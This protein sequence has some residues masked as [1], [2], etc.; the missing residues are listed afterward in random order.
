MPEG[1]WIS[2]G[3][4]VAVAPAAGIPKKMCQPART[5]LQAVTT[6]FWNCAHTLPFLCN[7]HCTHGVCVALLTS[8][9]GASYGALVGLIVPVVVPVVVA[10]VVLSLAVTLCSVIK[11]QFSV[12]GSS[13]KPQKHGTQMGGRQGGEM[14]HGQP[15]ISACLL[16]CL[17]SCCST[18]APAAAAFVGPTPGVEEYVDT[19]S[20]PSPDI[21]PKGC[22]CTAIKHEP[23]YGVVDVLVISGSFRVSRNT[24]QTEKPASHTTALFN[25]DS[26]TE[27]QCCKQIVNV[28]QM[29]FLTMNYRLINHRR[30]RGWRMRGFRII[31]DWCYDFDAEWSL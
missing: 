3:G 1:T 24:P 26:A 31:V 25:P 30:D 13:C 6:S 11:I 2:V 8:W 4:D 22:D 16:G 18:A 27:V 7:S 17:C 19:A 20:Y 15:D 10:L 29:R 9:M 21:A 28:E 12:S 14:Q 23:R 5:G